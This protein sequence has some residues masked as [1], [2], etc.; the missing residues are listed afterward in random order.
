MEELAEKYSIARMTVRRHL[1]KQ[2]YANPKNTLETERIDRAVELYQAGFT[3]QQVADRI[4]SNRDTV[5][6][7][8]I[9]RNIP[10]RP[11]GVR[12]EIDPAYL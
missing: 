3:L 1:D 8:L 4:S 7:A 9:S 5:R 2:G 10:R 6:E 11:K 12:V